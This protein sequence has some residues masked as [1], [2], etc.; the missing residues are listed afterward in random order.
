VEAPA[1]IVRKACILAAQ[2]GLLRTARNQA[3]ALGTSTLFLEQKLLKSSQ[4]KRLADVPFELKG[5]AIKT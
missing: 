2:G 1:P 5:T 3:G 4:V